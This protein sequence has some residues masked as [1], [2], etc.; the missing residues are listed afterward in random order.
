[1]QNAGSQLQIWTQREDQ[2]SLDGAPEW[3]C[4]RTIELVQPKEVT[5]GSGPYIMGEKRGTLLVRNLEQPSVYAADLEIGTVEEVADWPD[6]HQ[7]GRASCR[8]R[9]YVLV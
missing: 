3:L 7:I 8:E 5:Q 6:I 9:V 1:M 2:L 4:A